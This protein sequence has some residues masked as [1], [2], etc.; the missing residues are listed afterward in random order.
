MLQGAASSFV[1][2][3]GGHT[4]PQPPAGGVSDLLGLAGYESSDDSAAQGSRAPAEQAVSSLPQK[5]AVPAHATAALALPNAIQE[6]A[7][8]TGVLLRGAVRSFL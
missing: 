4:Q 3:T 7:G 8:A 6:A 2:V 1:D 5:K